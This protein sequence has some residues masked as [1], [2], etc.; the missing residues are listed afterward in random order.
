MKN[1]PNGIRMTEADKVLEAY[2]YRF[3]R[4]K[5]SHR[6]YINSEGDVITIKSENPLKKSIYK[7]Y[8]KQNRRII[9]LFNPMI[10]LL[11]LYA[12]Y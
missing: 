7:R 10:C 5:G 1:Q 12:K 9:L 8:F 4:Q 3:D 11:L 6:Q 2:G